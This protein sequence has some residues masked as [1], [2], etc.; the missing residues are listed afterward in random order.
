MLHFVRKP[1]LL[2]VALALTG[3]GGGS[4]TAQDTASNGTLPAVQPLSVELTVQPSALH[5]TSGTPQTFTATVQYAGTLNASSTDT[6]IARVDPASQ[7]A[8]HAAG[9]KGHS[10]VF[11]VTPVASGSADI[12]VTDKKGHQA[13]VHVTVETL[14]L[15]VSNFDWRTGESSITIYSGDANGNAPPLR[16]IAGGNTGLNSVMGIA[17][18]GNGQI[19]VPTRDTN[20]VRIFGPAAEGDAA[21][22]RT[23]SGPATGLC[24]PQGIALDL[25]GRTYVSNSCQAGDSITVY[26]PGASGDISP[27]AKIQ[28][29]A[30]DL[31]APRG[32]TLDAQGDLFVANTC[33]FFTPTNLPRVTVYSPLAN[34]DVPPIRTITGPDTQLIG[35]GSI[36]AG[37][38]TLYVGIL[39]TPGSIRMYALDATGDVIPTGS[40]SGAATG[41]DDVAAI[42]LDGRGTIYA[43]NYYIGTLSAFAPGATGNIA[44]VR[45]ISGAETLLAGP[46]GIAVH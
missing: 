37:S 10:A 25:A 12:I 9:Q 22:I 19:Y 45:S 8:S 2:I 43:V 3:C 31:C 17:V 33:P 14:K 13:D 39:N 36:A 11:T 41:L 34:G 4:L 1:V 42:T 18:D 35:A 32:M 5:F 21:P 20:S 7:D 6:A 38:Q 26:A 46:D 28:G 29:P 15:Y 16:R 40:L 44:P 27:I 30:A 23:I 24:S